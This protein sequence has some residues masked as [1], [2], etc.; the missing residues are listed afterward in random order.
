MFNLQLGNNFK[1]LPVL[2]LWVLLVLL[3]AIS[4]MESRLLLKE[5]LAGLWLLII[6]A[7]DNVLL[8]RDLLGLGLEFIEGSS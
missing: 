4:D 2:L 1:P 6:S 7:R 8:L 5:R 3:F